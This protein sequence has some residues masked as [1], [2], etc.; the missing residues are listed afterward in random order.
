MK[1]QLEICT[2]DLLSVQAAVDG[3]A[4]RIELCSALSEGGVTPSFGLMASARKIA[5]E[6]RMHVLI[7][8]REGDFVYDE[9]EV[10][11]MI[12]DICAARLAGADG[13]VIGALTREGQLDLDACMRMIEAANGMSVTF[14]RAF[15]RV[16][17]PHGALELLIKLGVDRVLT[18]G[19]A[20]SAQ[21]GA[22]L[23]GELVKQA[24]GR[25][26]ILAGAGVGPGNA[27][28][29]IARGGVGE[30]HASAREAMVEDQPEVKVKMGSNDGAPRM[31]TSARIVKAI[32]EQIDSI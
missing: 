20:P 27:A 28:D 9:R 15:D 17:D 25:I 1:R 4:D 21:E 10:E 26:I 8:P 22:G 24:D 19:Q 29:I 5:K 7:R 30:L 3:G 12:G 18:S 11:C 16:N 23:L 31:V 13:V 6:I 32:R 2:G 14:H